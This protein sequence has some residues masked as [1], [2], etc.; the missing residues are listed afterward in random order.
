MMIEKN[1]AAIIPCILLKIISEFSEKRSAGKG[2]SGRTFFVL[3]RR[4]A[5]NA[6]KVCDTQRDTGGRGRELFLF[7]Y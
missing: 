4:G 1:A 2:I 3:N 7:S 5:E 6:K